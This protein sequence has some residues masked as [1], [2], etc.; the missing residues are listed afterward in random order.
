GFQKSTDGRMS[1][2]ACVLLAPY[3]AGAWINSRAWTR[4]DPAP[5]SVQ[6]VVSLGRLPDRGVAAKFASVIDL[7]AELP[8]PYL[9]KGWRTFPPLDLVTPESDLLRAAAAA[10]EDARARGSVLVCCALGL[11]RSA[12]ALA[13]WLVASG[14]ADSVAAAV[15]Q[16]RQ[17]RPRIVLGDAALAA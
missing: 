8:C 10:I 16:I 1:L 7:S 11:S 9:H 17:V 15:A 14:H 2:A 3:L 12:C 4:G 6:G 5:V 13:T